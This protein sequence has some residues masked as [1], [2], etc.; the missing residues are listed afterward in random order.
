[1]TLGSFLAWCIYVFFLPFLAIVMILVHYGLA[2]IRLRA[3]K[4]ARS[5]PSWLYPYCVAAGMAF[6]QFVRVFYKP[7]VA[8]LIEAKQGEDADEDETG[9]P[10]SPEGRL[11]F[12]HRQLRRIRK[13]ES[14]DRL[15]WKL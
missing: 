15:V 13:G 11:R 3:R 12:F 1:M 6:L 14:V 5:K 7:D 8:Y 2:R 9:D 10:E 4:R